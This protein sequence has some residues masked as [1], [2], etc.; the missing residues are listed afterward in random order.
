MREIMIVIW[1]EEDTCYVCVDGFPVPPKRVK[2]EIDSLDGV[3][4]LSTEVHPCYVCFKTD[5]SKPR[6]SCYVGS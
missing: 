3:T 4:H 1:P 5:H 2:V 6:I